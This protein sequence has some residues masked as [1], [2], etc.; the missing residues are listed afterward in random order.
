MA[1]IWGGCN[2][3]CVGG[4]PE[5]PGCRRPRTGATCGQVQASPA[6]YYHEIVKCPG[7][8]ASVGDGVT[9]GERR[10]GGTVRC[11]H[12]VEAWWL[13]RRWRWRLAGP[14]TLILASLRHQ[15]WND[16]VVTQAPWMDRAEQAGVI[17]KGTR[18]GA[19]RNTLVLAR[20]AGVAP[21]NDTV[22]ATDPTPAASIDGPAVLAA[23]GGWRC[24][25]QASP[26]RQGSRSC[27]TPAPPRGV[28]FTRPTCAPTRS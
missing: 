23:M 2:A 1:G 13:G 3:A 15:V 18:T 12:V 19:W 7:R 21:A 27:W 4:V 11:C 6:N 5:M 9:Q 26:I 25:F 17:E 20:A 14:P 16:V 8:C 28:W 22:A 24:M 10:R